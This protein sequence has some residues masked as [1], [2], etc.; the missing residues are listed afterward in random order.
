MDSGWSMKHVHR[1]IV[2]S[3][4][5]QQ[6]SRLDRDD[7]QVS[8]E[9][10]LYTRGP[11]HRLSA[12][13]VRDNALSIAGMLSKRMFGPSVK[14]VQPEGLWRVIGKVDNSYRPSHGENRYRRGLYTYW[15]RSAPYPSF[16]AFDAP[17][18]AACTVNRGR[19]NTPLQA[20]TLMN[21][22]VYL[23]L[24]AGLT[25]VVLT[26]KENEAVDIQLAYAFRRCVSRQPNERELEI[27]RT[28]Y[29]KH[30]KRFQ[31]DPKSADA[32]WDNWP[33]PKNISKPVL[34][35][36]FLLSNTLLNLDE[37]ITKG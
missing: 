35:T 34:A 31:A 22:P 27:L 14:P 37:T 6:S 30:L 13:E 29:D 16:V 28:Q 11:R 4:V 10:R 26:H 19:T 24:A 15:R 12:E 25:N 18:R 23:E 7:L 36:W 21:D 33:A 9:N 20:L 1:L 8:Q 32:L 17:D 5:Y 3:A 2:T